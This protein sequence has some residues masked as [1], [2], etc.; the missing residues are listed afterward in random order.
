MFLGDD[1]DDGYRRAAAHCGIRT[2]AAPS[3]QRTKSVDEIA[4]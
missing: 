1:G 2:D 4:G 3:T